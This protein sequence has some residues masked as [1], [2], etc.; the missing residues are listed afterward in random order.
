MLIVTTDGLPGYEIR[1]VLGE[2]FGVAVQT[3][4]GA[5]APT[6]ASPSSGTFRV[7]GEQPGLGL[8]QA[9]REAVQRLAEE[10][11]RMGATAVVG[12]TFDNAFVSSGSGRGGHEVCAYGTA[13]V[14]EPAAPQPQH[15]SGG[16][17]KPAAPQPPVP[18][19]VDQ[20]GRPPMVARN[21]TIGLHGENPR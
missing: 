15:P 4:Q 17:A 9:R 13:V 16:Y 2:V 5:A 6:G 14:A 12:M 10:A 11:R 21:L 19:Y 3:D 1:R 8:S 7:T 20:P 18:P